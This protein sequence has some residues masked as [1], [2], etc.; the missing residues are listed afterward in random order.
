M[1]PEVFYSDVLILEGFLWIRSFF[2]KVF[3]S[4]LR[5]LL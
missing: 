2:S 4:F 3:Y 1:F 5:F